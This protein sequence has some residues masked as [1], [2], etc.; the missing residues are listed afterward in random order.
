MAIKIAQKKSKSEQLRAILTKI[1][2]NVVVWLT[3]YCLICIALPFVQV[4]FVYCSVAIHGGFT[5]F[6]LSA[7]SVSPSVVVVEWFFILK[8]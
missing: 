2:F 7:G 4:R 3:S 5:P 8:E 1:V 6:G